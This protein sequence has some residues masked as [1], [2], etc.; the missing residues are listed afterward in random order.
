MSM[1]PYRDGQQLLC[2]MGGLPTLRLRQEAVATAADHIAWVNILGGGMCQSPTNPTV[3]SQTA[4]GGA[5]VPAMCQPN[6]P[7]KWMG[8]SI[9]EVSGNPPE[10]VVMQH[11]Q[12]LCIWGGMIGPV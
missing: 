5:L 11:S 10:G 12:L 8:V 4:A 2:S 3:A 7:N 6:C 9:T 1:P